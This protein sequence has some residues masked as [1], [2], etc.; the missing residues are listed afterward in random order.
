MA[1]ATTGT[2]LAEGWLRRNVPEGQLM[3]FAGTR[4]RG[5]NSG[6]NP[7]LCFTTT[8]VPQRMG[9]PLQGQYP[10]PSTWYSAKQ[11]VGHPSG[12]KHEQ[13]ED[14]FADQ[15]V[16]GDVQVGECLIDEFHKMTG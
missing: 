15:A 2:L 7:T 16:A 11:G 12:G 3:E 1:G 6:T 5:G 9:H 4:R 8:E 14:N 13:P 10:V